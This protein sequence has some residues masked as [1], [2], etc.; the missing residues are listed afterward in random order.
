MASNTAAARSSSTNAAYAGRCKVAN[1]ARLISGTSRH[2]RRS[3]CK[4]C[5]TSVHSRPVPA[6]CERARAT[7]LLHGG[8]QHACFVL[9]SADVCAMVLGKCFFASGQRLTAGVTDSNKT[10]VGYI[11]GAHG[12]APSW[13]VVRPTPFAKPIGTACKAKVLWF[14]FT[15]IVIWKDCCLGGGEAHPVCKNQLGRRAEPKSCGFSLLRLL[16]GKIVVWGGGEAHPV[17]KT[18]WDGVQ[19]QSLVVSLYSHSYLERL[20]FGGWWG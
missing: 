5:I 13:G 9:H 20:L 16:F 7:C 18:N 14:L 4:A 6:G 15:P 8:L 19:S 2:C 10:T 11:L 12:W 1:A 17:C 3:G